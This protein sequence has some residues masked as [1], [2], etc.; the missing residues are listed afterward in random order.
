[1]N[2]DGHRLECEWIGPSPAR[3]RSLV[4]LH[5]GLGSLSLWRDFPAALCRRT[6]CGGLVYSRQGHGRSEVFDGPRS[7]R[8]MHDEALSVLP[9]VLRHFGI[10][11]PVLVGH[12]DGGSIALIYAGSGLGD[13]AALVLEAP[14]VFVED[15]TVR[16]IRRLAARY[17]TRD[18][19]AR[20][21]RHHGSNVDSL[22]RSWSKV[23]LSSKFRRWNIE[24]C[25]PRVRCPA[26]V[27]Q[28]EDDEYGTL[29]Q[30]QTISAALGGAVEVL[31][32]PSCGHSPHIDQR[33]AV[34]HRMAR[35][36][37]ATALAKRR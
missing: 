8:F 13:V 4:F 1:M 34:E 29:A 3:T 37:R 27:I 31:T 24:D 35:F 17:R 15:L 23:W 36:I 9:Q 20:L 22:F 18:L 25:L 33:T 12:S 11:S 2:I 19:R 26:L 7:T 16:S 28:G 5:E 21:T 30:V 6:G 32:L 14:H 10:R